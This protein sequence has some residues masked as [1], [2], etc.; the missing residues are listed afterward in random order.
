MFN[1]AGHARRSQAS[2]RHRPTPLAP[3]PYMCFV[4]RLI[5]GFFLALVFHRC[6]A[7]HV[8]CPRSKRF[9][10]EGQGQTSDNLCAWSSIL[11]ALLAHLDPDSRTLEFAGKPLVD[12][13][14]EEMRNLVADDMQRN[15]SRALGDLTVKTVVETVAGFDM[16]VE[17]HA[18]RLRNGSYAGEMEFTLLTNSV[19]G[20]CVDIYMKRRHGLQRIMSV[21]R[22]GRITVSVVF[23]FNHYN[24]VFEVKPCSEYAGLQG[25]S[26]EKGTWW[27]QRDFAD[28]TP[29]CFKK[30]GRHPRRRKCGRKRKT[31]A[32]QTQGNKVSTADAAV[33][34]NAAK[35]TATEAAANAA[36]GTADDEDEAVKAAMA[37]AEV[38]AVRFSPI[39][40]RQLRRLWK[41]R[42][43][44]ACPM[45]K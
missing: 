35:I 17:T 42:R 9:V 37:K 36:K 38:N 16:S 14:P 25:D 3:V 20:L 13:S 44:R 28:L 43:A 2:R 31:K 4:K 24:P 26:L 32:T 22:S 8:L 11:Q 30:V 5:R 18:I 29:A 6:C 21:N 10:K 27:N 39:R 15:P 45:R 34:G 19:P 33:E 23:T 7:T 1:W 12:L 40:R 41:R